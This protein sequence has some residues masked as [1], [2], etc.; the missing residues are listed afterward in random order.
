MEESK[1]QME[2]IDLEA[3]TAPAAAETSEK[4]V[5]KADL[6]YAIEDVPPWYMCCLLGFQHYLTMFGATLAIPFILTPSLCI[7]EGD[8]AR[9]YLISTIFFVSGLVT[10][11]QAT[12]GV[13]LPS[14]SASCTL[15]A[16]S[17]AG[18]RALLCCPHLRRTSILPG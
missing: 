4:K 3:V 1:V 18:W 10:L 16:V 17:A 9:G 15:R 11:V 13:R 7:E 8:P 2:E 5:T 6:A 14:T 12:I